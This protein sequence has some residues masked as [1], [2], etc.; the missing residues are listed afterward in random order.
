MPKFKF[1]SF[2]RIRLDIPIRV[3]RSTL[4]MYSSGSTSSNLN[5][6]PPNR[7]KNFLDVRVV[8]ISFSFVSNRVTSA[9]PTITPFPYATFPIIEYLSSNY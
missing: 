1:L 9:S 5:F 8:D 6:P 4:I 2:N 7:F 3:P